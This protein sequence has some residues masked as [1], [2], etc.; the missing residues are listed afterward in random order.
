MIFLVIIYGLII[1][2]FLNI[3]IYRIPRSESIVFPSSHCPYCNKKLKWYDNIPIFSYLSL[4]RECRYCNIRISSIYP[5]VELFNAVIYIAMYIKFG[6]AFDFFFYALI[7]S[8]LIIITFIDLKNM[9]IP[10][11]LVLIIFISS[12]IYKATIYYIGI[13]PQIISSIY[14]LIISGILFLAIVIL[15]R[16]GM[17]GGDVTLIAALGFILG[18]KYILLNMFLSFLLGAVISM[19]LLASRIKTRKDPI[20]FG[21]F[22]IISFLITVF[23]GQDIIDWYLK[24]SS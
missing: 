21:P 17:G 20:P 10:D 12:I 16:G 9:I 4:K 1:G 3:C 22:I 8:I 19:F 5:I 23:W 14:G 2:S 6:F 11:V 7:S 13:N 24:I 18:L 15:S